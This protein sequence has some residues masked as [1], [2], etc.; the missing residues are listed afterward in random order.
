MAVLKNMPWGYHAFATLLNANCPSGEKWAY[1]D[2]EGGQAHW[3]PDHPLPSIVTYQVRENDLADDPPADKVLVSKTRSS[4]S[5]SARFS[6]SSSSSSSDTGS[7]S[8]RTMSLSGNGDA[9]RNGGTG[10]A[11]L[12]SSDGELQDTSLA[13]LDTFLTKIPPKVGR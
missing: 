6:S 9:G 12:L 3:F 1:F 13:T 5:S 11:G 7:R 8:G 10:E 2:A 4:S